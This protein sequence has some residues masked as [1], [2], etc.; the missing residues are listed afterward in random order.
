MA[1]IRQIEQAGLMPA[2]AVAE[3]ALRSHQRGRRNRL[4]RRT[5]QT[6][7]CALAVLAGI[8]WWL[9]LKQ[10]DVARTE[11][12][13][14]DRT[15][16]FMVAL[17]QLNDPSESR[18]NA[19]TVK[20]VLDKGAKEI[21]ND[22]SVDSLAREPRVRAE[23]LTAMGEAYSGLGLYKPAGELLTQASGDIQSSSVPDQARVCTLVASGR[24]FY[25]SG[26]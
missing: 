19:V 21:Q 6:G 10:R 5:V 11:A 15:T 18:G 7:I 20:E 12:A 13:T 23:L 14:S 26:H 9:A 22:K 8:A 1:A 2:G 25:L 17:F 24:P 16:Q 3:Y 4:I